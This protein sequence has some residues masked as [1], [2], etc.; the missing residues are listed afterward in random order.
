M[1]RFIATLFALTPAIALHASPPK[2]AT[3]IPPV[4]SLVA[5]V[6]DGVGT[7]DLIMQPGMSPHDYSMRPSEAQMLEQAD[8]VFWIGHDLTP[9]LEKPLDVLAGSAV[10]I[11][12]L[13]VDGI[14]THEFRDNAVF[15]EHD[16]DH[17][18]E[19][20]HDHGP[21]DPH[22]WLDPE[23]AKVWI[24][25]IAEALSEQDPENT[26]KYQGN[27]QAALTE[28]DAASTE[29]EEMLKPVRG[30]NFV[31]FHDA[32]QYFERRF[33]IASTGSIAAGDAVDP[34]AGRIAEIS[35]RVQALDVHCV[36]SEPQFDPGIIAA[37]DA[38]GALNTAVIDPLG[39]SLPVDSS[40][41]T[42]LL[43]GIAGQMSTCLSDRSG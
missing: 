25:L 35:E 38:S 40:L 13:D 37:L 1:Y 8:L 27:A 7:P 32:Y 28:I 23:N 43:T 31:V 26:A 18:H 14:E 20:H 6:M 42:S 19:D 4:F 24:A 39:A 5:R 2:V 34:S 15:D 9:S 11:E 30:R 21:T 33:D 36:F 10:V 3:D 12:L 41:Y 16:H 29:I 22:A 17:D